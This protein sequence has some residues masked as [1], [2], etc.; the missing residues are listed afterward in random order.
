MF[1][2][3]NILSIFSRPRLV[4]NLKPDVF[5]LLYV[6]KTRHL[7]REDEKIFRPKEAKNVEVVDTTKN[8]QLAVKG[9]M[10]TLGFAATIVPEDYV[11]EVLSGGDWGSPQIQQNQTQTKYNHT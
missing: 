6:E 9:P 11:E 3:V 2:T 8:R 4:S 1:Y 7:V 10:T 5:R